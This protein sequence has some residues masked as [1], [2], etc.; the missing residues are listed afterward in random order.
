MKALLVDGLNLVRRIHAAVP[1][2]EPQAD[3][4][5]EGAHMSGVIESSVA[6]LKRALRFH[7]PS[8]VVMVFESDA[9]TWRH[10]LLA[11]YKR[12]RP[13]MPEDLRDG[14]PALQRAFLGFGVRCFER[15]GY[16]ADDI[17]GTI[18]RKIEKG[19]GKSTI[20]STDRHY[21]QLLSPSI[22]VYDHFAQRPL[23]EAM[24]LQ[25]FGVAP[26]DLPYFFALTGDPGKSIPGIPGVGAR[27][28]ARL[29][30]E[31]PDLETLL[32]AAR[33]MKGKIASKILSGADTARTGLALFQ[34]RTD[35]ELGI[36]LSQ[37]RYL[38]AE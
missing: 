21:C 36:N 24:I 15:P 23:D 4:V 25:R 3:Q 1:M 11:D 20:L 22:A 16:E 6:S 38:P 30:A 37:L 12:N 9:P 28:A 18:A 26:R 33:D 2:P 10:R 32:E 14:L 19:G 34:L 7:T 17:I 27:T 5:P 13:A 35:I 31:Y 29:V 8:H